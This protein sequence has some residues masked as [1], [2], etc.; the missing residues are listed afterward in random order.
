MMANGDRKSNSDVV[1]VKATAPATGKGRQHQRLKDAAT[2]ATLG[3]T[4]DINKVVII[5]F[6]ET[7]HYFFVAFC[8]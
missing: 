1:M 5:Y 2:T 4:D 3:T 7:T 8:A 6:Q